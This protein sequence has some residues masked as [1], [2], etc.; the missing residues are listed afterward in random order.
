MLLTSDEITKSKHVIAVQRE[1]ARQFT[2]AH[3]FKRLLRRSFFV[4]W[5]LT[6]Q[7][8][9]DGFF[10]PLLMNDLLNCIDI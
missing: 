5:I 2:P 3:H 10:P 6:H 1:R 7:A 4:G 9:L 8:K